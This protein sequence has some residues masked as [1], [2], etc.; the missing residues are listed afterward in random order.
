MEGAE[1]I[2]GRELKWC[3]RLILKF[4][5]YA[6]EYL[7]LW[8]GFFNTILFLIELNLYSVLELNEIEKAY[9]FAT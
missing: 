1:Q 3:T 5:N 6:L 2:K 7:D 4:C 9:D 8:E